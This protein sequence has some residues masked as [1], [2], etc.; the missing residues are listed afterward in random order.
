MVSHMNL[1]ECGNSGQKGELD[2]IGRMFDYV[3]WE[4]MVNSI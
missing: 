1:R 4:D 3:T 2:I